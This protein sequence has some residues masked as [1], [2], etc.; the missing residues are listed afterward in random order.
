MGV[1]IL[2]LDGGGIRGILTA[3]LLQRLDEAVPGWLDHVDLFAGTSTGGI[4]ALGLAMGLTPGEL[5]QLYQIHG[6]VIFQN[7][8]WWRVKTGFGLWGPKYDGENL[9]RVLK[10]T[11]GERR[12][13]DLPRQVLVSAF[14]L[15]Q[16]GPPILRWKPKFLY[17]RNAQNGEVLVADAAWRGAAAPA[18]FKAYQ[19][20]IDGAV[21]ANNPSLVAL[22]HVMREQERDVRLLS[23]G[24]GYRKNTHDTDPMFGVIGWGQRLAELFF[25]G[26]N[27]VVDEQCQQ[28]LHEAY[29]RVDCGLEKHV[30]L[31]GVSHIDTLLAAADKED[32]TETVAFIRTWVD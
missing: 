32:L 14:E 9:G 20:H 16:Q 27:G 2:S 21:A 19:G 3:R 4:L 15:G 25:D 17:N 29:H 31:D 30:P 22:A 7:T 11:F 12:L 6:K 24:T 28:L 5:V 10:A 8:F 1:R 26:M 18:Y 23:V 13:K